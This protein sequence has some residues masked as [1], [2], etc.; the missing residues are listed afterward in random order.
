MI[1]KNLDP[2]IICF[3]IFEYGFDFEQIF[4]REKKTPRYSTTDTAESCG[5]FSNKNFDIIFM[6]VSCFMT[7]VKALN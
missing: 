6:R 2:L 1:L 3:S 7:K 5:F 4:A